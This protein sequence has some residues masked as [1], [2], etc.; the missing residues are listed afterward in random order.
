VS[1]NTAI[2]WTDATWSPVTGCTKVSDGCT[3]C[4]IDRTPPFRMQHRRFNGTEPGATTGVKLHSERLHIPLKWRKPR[5]I[6]VCSLADLFQDEVPDQFIAEVF[7]A[8]ALAP[9]HTFQCLTKRHARMRSLLNSLDFQ[10]MVAKAIDARA[11]EVDHDAAE[12]WAPIAGFEHY[13]ASSHGRI[14]GASG[15]LKPHINPQTG[16][17]AVTLWANNTPKV[18][19]VH[20]LVLLAHQPDAPAG[21]EACHRNGDKRDNRLANL[22]WGTRS[23]NQREKVRHGSRGGP[24][25]LTPDQVEAIRLQ[26]K[27]GLTQQAIADEFGISRSLVSM[28]ESGRVWGAPDIVWPLPNVWVGVSV[29][30]QKWADIRIPAL[31]D[32]PAA[33]R[34]ISAEPLLGP[35]VLAPGWLTQLRSLRPG[36]DWCVVGG[37]SGSGARPMHPDWARS[38]RDQCLAAGVPFHFKQHGQHAPVHDKPAHGDLWLAVDGATADWHHGDGHIRVGDGDHLWPGSRTALVRRARSKHDAGRVLD[39]QTWDQYPEAS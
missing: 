26:R 5:R 9:Q 29:E 13:Q 18:L 15:F 36:L 21:A 1:T 37:E 11:V 20:R 10:H 38:L 23:E 35:V 24:Q 3:H 8:M 33:V 27:A 28:I 19:P 17:D 7:A 34:W 32:T 22:R 12:R 39:G 25:K 14:R 31:L 4:Y 6:F 30:N 16:R 2:S